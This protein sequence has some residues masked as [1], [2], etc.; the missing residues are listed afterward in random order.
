M[1]LVEPR[2]PSLWMRDVCLPL[3]ADRGFDQANGGFVERFNL[4]TGAADAPVKRVRVQARQ[5]YV[6]SHA[7][8]LGWSDK[9]DLA[10]KALAFVEPA[11]SEQT[12]WARSLTV[13][14]ELND[15]TPDLY[16]NAFM[17]FALG[18]AFRATG[19]KHLA[20]RARQSLLAIRRTLARPDGRGYLPEKPVAG[21][22]MQN[23]HMHMLEACLVLAEG[24]GEA[25]YFE[26]ASKILELFRSCFYEASNATLAE[27]FDPAWQRASGDAGRITEPG[28]QFEW[29][30][31]LAEYARIVGG[32]TPAEAEGLFR[33]AETFGVDKATGLAVAEVR[34]DGKVLNS[35][36]RTWP[37]TELLKARLAGLEA[38][39]VSQ[40]PLVRQVIDNLFDL[41]LDRPEPGL[42]IDLFDSQH[43]PL[44]DNVPASTLYHVF[45]A[46]SEAERLGPLWKTPEDGRWT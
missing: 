44:V 27:Y 24:T 35:N 18:W 10:L 15:S 39:D 32:P 4:K 45:L 9:A 41:F 16:D 21:H 7:Q 26:E 2:S 3:W 6:F 17:L 8:M 38:G 40:A 28:H 23:P 30:W 22:W 1:T 31:L 33:F 36:L 43:C 34:D 46:F 14:G 12:G 25:I 20:D 13:T 19:E 42:W 37:Q 29:R 11:W 5:I